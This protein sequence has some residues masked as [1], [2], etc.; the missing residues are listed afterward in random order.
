MRIDYNR[1]IR[2]KMGDTVAGM[3]ELSTSE[4][5]EGACLHEESPYRGHVG[6]PQILERSCGREN[7]LALSGTHQKN[8]GQGAQ[9]SGESV[10]LR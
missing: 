1:N 10:V 3:W 6:H 2:Q 5:T 9:V 4:E 8:G 7:R